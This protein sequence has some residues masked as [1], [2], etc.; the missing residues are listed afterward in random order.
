MSE[1]VQSHSIADGFT[2]F[3]GIAPALDD[4]LRKDVYFIRHEV[5]AREFGFEPVREDQQETDAYDR[6][7]V[8]C[9]L[10]TAD[11]TQNLVGCARLVLPDPAKPEAPLPFEVS[12]RDTIDRSIIDPR[13]LD[14]SR[15]A[16]V[17]RLAVMANFR[18]RKGE[19]NHAVPIQ[20]QDFG[21]SVQPRFP[22]IPVSLYIGCVVLAERHGIDYL[23][24]LTE[25]RLAQHF[26]KLGVKIEP[27]GAPIEHR[28]TRVPSIIHVASVVPSLRAFVKPLWQVIH[29]QIDEAYD[30]AV[31]PA[32]IAKP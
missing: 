16:E 14:R 18:R 19:Q 3:F 32:A 17:S 1:P 4:E 6:Q 5:Y 29:R 22:Y 7:S 24:T 2:R 13:T 12:C 30:N 10:R 31:S 26:S 9:L 23:F 8:H 28:G 20:D 21:N 11:A 27:I 15:I 25:C